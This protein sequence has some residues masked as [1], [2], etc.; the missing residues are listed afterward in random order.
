MMWLGK[1]DKQIS[2]VLD[3]QKIL[4][5]SAYKAFQSIL[6]V[7]F[8]ASCST[9]FGA[10]K[11]TSFP[12]GA[13]I[14]NSDDGTT[15]GVTPATVWWKDSSSNRQHIALRFKKDGYYEKVASF[16]LSM[17]HKNVEDAKQDANLVE[18]SLLKKG[19]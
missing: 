11:I 14:I 2:S 1:F 18:V 3:M 4:T 13:E 6:L 7:A 17:R 15:L 19:E 10:A 16:W 8:L 12:S 9:H 5:N